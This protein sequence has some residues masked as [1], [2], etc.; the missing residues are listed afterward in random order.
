MR[1]VRVELDEGTNEEGRKIDV[2]GGRRS[3]GCLLGDFPLVRSVV[4][5]SLSRLNPVNEHTKE[6]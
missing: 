6:S 2:A 5:P 4:T 1:Y 3:E